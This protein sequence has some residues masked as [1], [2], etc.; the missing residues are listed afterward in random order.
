MQ[1]Q[2]TAFIVHRGGGAVLNFPD[3]HVTGNGR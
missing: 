2:G 3:R 1:T